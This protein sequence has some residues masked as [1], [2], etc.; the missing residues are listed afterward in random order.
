[1]KSAKNG[2]QQENPIV[3]HKLKTIHYSL[4]TFHYSLNKLSLLSRKTDSAGGKR[5]VFTV[6]KL[7]EKSAVFIDACADRLVYIFTL[8]YRDALAHKVGAA[9]V[10]LEARVSFGELLLCV[11]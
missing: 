9:A 11:G 6:V 7:D 3:H 5:L 8:S 4:F 10:F 1:M 2:E